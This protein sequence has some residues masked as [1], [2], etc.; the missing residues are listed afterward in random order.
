MHSV[1]KRMPGQNVPYIFVSYDKKQ[2]ITLDI[3]RKGKN[4]Q[5]PDIVTCKHISYRDKQP[6]CWKPSDPDPS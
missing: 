1:L 5:T 2:E 4:P 6:S 3:R